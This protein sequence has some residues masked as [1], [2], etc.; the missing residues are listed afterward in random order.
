MKSLKGLSTVVKRTFRV[1][2]IHVHVYRYLVLS[3]RGTPNSLFVLFVIRLLLN[4]R[5]S[6]PS[7]WSHCLEASVRMERRFNIYSIIWRYL[8][9]YLKISSNKL[10]I[11]S[12][13]WRYKCIFKWIE[14]IFKWIKDIFKYLKISLIH[15]KISLIHL[16]IS[17]IHLK[18]SLIHLKI[19][20][21]HLKISSNIWRYLQI[22]EYMLKRCSTCPNI[23]LTFQVNCNL[24]HSRASEIMFVMPTEATNMTKISM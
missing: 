21:I 22:I 2:Y 20:L 10:K 9:K 13:I 12:N 1:K 8:F 4:L 17:S 5:T 6:G 24:A 16:K 3:F 15:L 23:I 7:D 19:S 11:S 14:D 18:I